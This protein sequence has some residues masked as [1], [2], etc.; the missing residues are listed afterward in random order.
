MFL[1]GQMKNWIRRFSLFTSIFQ[2]LESQ[3]SMVIFAIG[4]K[5][6][7]GNAS[8]KLSIEFPLQI[9]HSDVLASDVDVIRCLGQI[10]CGIMM[11]SMASHTFLQEV[12]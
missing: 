3:C 4:E 9:A 12:W 6:S 11:A 8:V 5:M 10:T 1:N 2:M 7:L